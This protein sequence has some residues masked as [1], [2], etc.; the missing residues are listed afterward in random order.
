MKIFIISL[1]IQKPANIAALCRR[2]RCSRAGPS[3]SLQDTVVRVISDK[4]NYTVL[5]GKKKKERNERKTFPLN[6]L[7]LD[8]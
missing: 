5:I 7:C 8:R 6:P 2:Y 4:S 3:E 1:P